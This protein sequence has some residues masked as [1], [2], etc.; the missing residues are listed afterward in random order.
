MIVP[1]RSAWGSN[2]MSAIKMIV[3][4]NKCPLF[5]LKA[6]ESGLKCRCPPWFYNQWFPWVIEVQSLPA[7]PCSGARE[8]DLSRNSV[9]WS[10]VHALNVDSSGVRRVKNWEMP[11]LNIRHSDNYRSCWAIMIHSLFC[12]YYSKWCPRK[13]R[14]MIGSYQQNRRRYFW[15]RP[16]EQF[17]TFLAHPVFFHTI[18]TLEKGR[19]ISQNVVCW[20]VGRMYLHFDQTIATVKFSTSLSWT[21]RLWIERA[22]DMSWFSNSYWTLSSKTRWLS[23]PPTLLIMISLEW[24]KGESLKF[25]LESV[26]SIDFLWARAFLKTIAENWIKGSRMLYQ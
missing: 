15:D 11:K 18:V 12:L 8:D 23:V 10:W 3:D 14:A 19:V 2:S 6:C 5:I 7:R 24:P 13:R 17:W 21:T 20:S 16:R 1:R 9:D 26:S 22:S 25:G 4:G